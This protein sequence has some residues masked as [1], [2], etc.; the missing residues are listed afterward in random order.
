[1]TPQVGLRAPGFAFT[2]LVLAV[3]AFTAVTPASASS[4]AWTAPGS[5]ITT[6]AL[7]GEWNLG[8]EFVANS[9][10][11]VSALG[12]YAGNIYNTWEEVTLYDASGNVLTDTSIN[13]STAWLYDGYYWSPAGAQLIAGD[14]YYV[15]D[16]T[17]GNDTGAGSGYGPDPMTS[18]WATFV[19][20]VSDNNGIPDLPA[21]NTTTD[22]PAFYGPNVLDAPNAPEPESLLLLGSGLIGLAG[23][24]RLMR[25]RK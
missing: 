1:M 9:N 21:G 11:T 15:V 16:F 13:L 2:L 10:E 19:G 18:S 6:N 12:I 17:N 3:V 20:E 24:V 4:I 8:I 5:G 7:N 23:F 22:G 14:T 25:R